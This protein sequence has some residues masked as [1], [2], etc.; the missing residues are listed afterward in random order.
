[1]SRQRRREAEQIEALLKSNLGHLAL[2]RPCVRL[3]P[4]IAGGDDVEVAALHPYRALSTAALKALIA[5][6]LARVEL[7]GPLLADGPV[8]AETRTRHLEMSQTDTMIFRP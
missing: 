7:H 8:I 2:A 4:G 3:R 6:V 5:D 1:L